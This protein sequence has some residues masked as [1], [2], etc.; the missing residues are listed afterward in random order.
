MAL[1]FLAE[2][3]EIVLELPPIA[4]CFLAKV[5]VVLPEPIAIP[6]PFPGGLVAGAAKAGVMAKDEATAIAIVVILECEDLVH[7]FCVR[8]FSPNSKEMYGY[9]INHFSPLTI[10]GFPPNCWGT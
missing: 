3:S 10:M 4:I 2:P 8:M 6:T 7:F 9:T 1:S 5:S